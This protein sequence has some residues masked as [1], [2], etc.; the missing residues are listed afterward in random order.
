MNG[1]TVRTVVGIGLLILSLVLAARGAGS[2]GAAPLPPI[3]HPT[4]AHLVLELAMTGADF[5][6]GESYEVTARGEGD[7]D[8]ARQAM[9]FSYEMQL[10]PDLADTDPLFG[11]TQVAIVLVDG[12]FYALDPAT[13][14]W[15]WLEMPA[16]LP[17]Q[18][19]T[20]DYAEWSTQYGGNSLEFTNLGSADVNGAATTHWHAEYDLASMFSG[21][22]GVDPAAEP[23]PSA[24]P[25]PTMLVTMDLWIGDADNYVHRASSGMSFTLSDESGL[26]G[27][28]SYVM[29]MT[30]S[31]FDQP[32]EI[33]APAGA[34]PIADGDTADVAMG[35]LS[36]LFGTP[37]DSSLFGVPGGTTAGDEPG[38]SDT[39]TAAPWAPVASPTPRRNNGGI[40]IATAEPTATAKPSP[41]PTVA[42]TATPTAPP[43][44]ATATAAIV[45]NAAIPPT[46]AA[47]AQTAAVPTV[48][49]SASTP[50]ARSSTI[51]LIVGGAALVLLIALSGGL[52][53][54]GRRMQ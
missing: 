41:T 24:E 16:D 34:V 10:P 49:D 48:Q 13:Q 22:L 36:S 1:R 6:S 2:V 21:L 23:E 54:A 45:A 40:V 47:Q 31:N 27:S 25:L 51:P 17:G 30:Y 50:A 44:T 39:G 11:S 19:F 12:R 28:F 7:L 52:I 29:T 4:T 38:A 18:Q 43:P 8:N 35:T 42:P 37:F 32:V 20:P 3:A 26:G 9:Q 15:Q 33:V 46:V 14:Q 53:V 5:T